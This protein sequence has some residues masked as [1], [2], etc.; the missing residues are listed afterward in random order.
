MI[1]TKKEYELTKKSLDEMYQLREEM[2][3]CTP[4]NGDAKIR[5]IDIAIE[6]LK[7]KLSEYESRVPQR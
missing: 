2:L 4:L 5:N 7:K 1:K 3:E 6:V